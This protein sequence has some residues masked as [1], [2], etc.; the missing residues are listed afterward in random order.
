MSKT[1]TEAIQARRTWDQRELR[2]NLPTGLTGI[3]VSNTGRMTC[4]DHGGMYLRGELNARP[5]ANYIV[6]PLDAW[7]RLSEFEAASLRN[8]LDILELCDICRG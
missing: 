4:K 3:F 7:Q 2:K 6:T 8:D 1:R 5:K